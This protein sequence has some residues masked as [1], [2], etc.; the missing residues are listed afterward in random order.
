MLADEFSKSESEYNSTKATWL[1][2]ELIAIPTFYFLGTV[3]AV[4]KQSV[5]N[6]FFYFPLLAALPLIV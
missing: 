3:I 6:N 5:A 2:S 1:C 4:N